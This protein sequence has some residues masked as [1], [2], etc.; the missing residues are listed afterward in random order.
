LYEEGL[1]LAGVAG[2]PGIPYSTIQNHAWV[3]SW[4]VR[5]RGGRK[6]PRLQAAKAKQIRRKLEKEESV[7]G[8]RAGTGQDRR[9]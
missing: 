1:S 8:A 3:E 9:S 6:D 4:P 5:R 2:K 7:W